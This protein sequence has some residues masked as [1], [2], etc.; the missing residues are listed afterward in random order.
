[1]KK[2]KCYQ[3]DDCFPTIKNIFDHLRAVHNVKDKLFSIKCVNN[4]K[5][6]KC[7]S[8]FLSFN[9]LR[10]HL[11]GCYSNGMIFDEEVISYKQ[12]GL[13]FCNK[14]CDLFTLSSF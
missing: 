5:F 4:F 7:S 8:T 13:K 10:S 3:C 11:D 2:Y 9:G 12:F 1:M 6:Y 14:L